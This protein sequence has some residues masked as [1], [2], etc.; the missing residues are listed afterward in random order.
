MKRTAKKLIYPQ[1]TLINTEKDKENNLRESAQSVEKHAFV[2]FLI[3][4]LEIV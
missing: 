2:S 1:I 3:A 4:G